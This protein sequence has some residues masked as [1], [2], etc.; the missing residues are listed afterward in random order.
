MHLKYETEAARFAQ[1]NGLDGVFFGVAKE[2]GSEVYHAGF[3]DETNTDGFT[4][5]WY[6]PFD[7]MLYDVIADETGVRW[8]SDSHRS[9]PQSYR[10]P[11]VP[12]A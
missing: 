6:T 2:D 8:R 11:N 1:R 4:G 12:D 9:Y 10:N 3:F 5:G 7:D